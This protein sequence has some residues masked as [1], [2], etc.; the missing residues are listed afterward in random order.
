MRKF[1]LA[2]LAA[3]VVMGGVVFADVDTGIGD[4]ATAS[5]DVNVT[6][7]ISQW[8]VLYIPSVDMNVDLGTV[9][10]SLY[11]P[12][13]N[14]WSSLSSSDHDVVVATNAP[15][16]FQLTISGTLASYPT[17]HPDPNGILDRLELSSA[18]LGISGPV[19]G[20]LTYDGSRGLTTASDITYTYT[21][22][23]DDIPGSYQVTVTYT[24]T[25]K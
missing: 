5:L 8:I 16:G 17:G 25:T 23:F 21:P 6:W 12:E 13:S 7:N 14:S 4:P 1:I 20:S 9:D 2:A 10:A 15:G 3:L 11:D 24:V 19:S 22:N 18:S